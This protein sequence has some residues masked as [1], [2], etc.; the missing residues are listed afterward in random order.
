MRVSF[1]SYPFALIWISA[2]AAYAQQD[3]GAEIDALHQT[4]DYAQPGAWR[5]SLDGPRLVEDAVDFIEGM[6]WQN[7]HY[8]CDFDTAPQAVEREI[9]M[10]V[11]ED[12]RHAFLFFPLRAEVKRAEADGIAR[13]EAAFLKIVE[14]DESQD[15]DAE[16]RALAAQVRAGAFGP[17]VQRNYTEV[18]QVLEGET[19]YS[20]EPLFTMRL[21]ARAEHAD[22]LIALVDAARQ[23]ACGKP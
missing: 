6:R 10:M 12:Q 4:T 15:P 8:L 5:Y 9:D 13:A 3:F 11:V 14:G 1:V 7:H 20:F 21:I 2:F 22:Q 18:T 23:S 17:M 16:Y 19:Q